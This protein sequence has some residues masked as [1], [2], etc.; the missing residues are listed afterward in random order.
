MNK[1]VII[2]S[3]SY[4]IL[5]KKIT[6]L[7]KTKAEIAE[8]LSLTSLDSDLSENGDFTTLLGNLEETEQ[9]LARLNLLL[10]N[11]EIFQKI[12]N[13]KLIG[14]GSKVTYKIIN[15]REEKNAEITDAVEAD[16]PQ[17]I[18]IYSPFGKKLLG[19]KVGDIF[20]NQGKNKHQVQILAIK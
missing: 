16:Q 4:S 10:A 7:E 13:S 5:K 8:R 9:N 6:S 11:A 19:K 3:E 14:L 2:T 1:K 20:D 15:T 12:S 18:S 17:K